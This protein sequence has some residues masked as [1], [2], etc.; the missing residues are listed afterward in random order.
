[1]T[2]EELHRRLHHAVR[3]LSDPP[4]PP[5]WNHRELHDILP[6]APLRSAAVLVGIVERNEGPAVLL[7]Q[8]TEHLANHAGQISFPGG[9][10]EAGDADAIATALRE[11]R[12]EVG[13]GAESITPFGYLD[14]LDTVSGFNVTPVVA[15]IVPGYVATINPGEV[16][17]AFEVPLAFFADPSN[18]RFRR[19]EYRGRQRD[20][21]EF[22]F[23]ER[24]IWGATAA[25]LL[26]LV[27]RME[28]VT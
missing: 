25:M 28:A 14:G 9:S 13:I 8:R 4:Q 3:P 12:E 23:G 15:D 10:A 7:T 5:G 20:I 21:V 22:H 27:R 6:D 19:M 16:A 1:V 18:L 2:R 17:A 26:S 24:N 11:T